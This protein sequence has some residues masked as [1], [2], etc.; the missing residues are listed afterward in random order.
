MDA[1]P[2]G[3]VF[4]AW[5]NDWDDVAK[6]KKAA[7]NLAS[8]GADVDFPVDGQCCRR[9]PSTVAIP[10]IV[11]TY[12][13]FGIRQTFFIPASCMETYPKAV[14]TI[15]EGGHEIGQHGYPHDNP[16]P[17]S[18]DEQAMWMDRCIDVIQRMTGQKPGGRRAPLYNFSNHSADLLVERGFRYDT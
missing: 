12:R 8:Q 5:T 13:H 7:L 2:D 1:R 3:E 17:Q 10:R 14:E 16:V 4:T 9:Q 11:E 15:L 6:S 18:R